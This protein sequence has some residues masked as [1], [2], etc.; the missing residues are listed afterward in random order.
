MVQK[1]SGLEIKGNERYKKASC[2]CP[3][4]GLA[5]PSRVDLPGMRLLSCQHAILL[6]WQKRTPALSLGHS[7]GQWLS[8]T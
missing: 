6:S 2:Q 1:V 5:P 3:E 7:V 4:L 8:L